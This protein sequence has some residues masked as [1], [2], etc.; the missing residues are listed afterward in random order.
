MR[1][2]CLSLCLNNS[3]ACLFIAYTAWLH[4]ADAIPDGDSGPCVFASPQGVW[5]TLPNNEQMLN[6]AFRE[7]RNVLLIFSV[8][9][10][11]KFQGETR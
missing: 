1:L 6:Q 2:L 7:S 4:V 5:S 8:K 10:S 11:G 9:E 3:S